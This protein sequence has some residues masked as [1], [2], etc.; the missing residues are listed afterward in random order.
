MGIGELKNGRL[1]LVMVAQHQLP[2]ADWAQWQRAIAK[3]SELLYDA[4]QGQLQIGN[5]Y[6]ADDGNGEDTADVVLYASGDPSF[7]Q[8]RFGARGAAV[9]L[10]PY[11]KR[12]VLTVLHELGHNIWNLGE[13]YSQ[14]TTSHV[15]DTSTPSPNA[16][17]IPILASGLST[18]QLVDEN[19]DALLTING[20]IE[21][22]AVVANTATS[23]TVDAD[24]SALP[25]SIGNTT[26]WIQRPAECAETATPNFCIMENSRSAAGELAPDGTWTPA[27]NPITEFCTDT[28]HDPDGDTA[29]QTRNADS[30]W[31]TIVATPGYT[32]LT[33]PNPA[34]PGPAVG[35]TPV[36]FYVLD[37]D[38]RFA[39]VLDRSYSMA[40]GNKL[41]DAQHGATYWV[42]FCAVAGDQL[43][44]VWYNHNRDVLLPLTDVGTLSPAARQQ[45]DTDINAITP[46]G[47]TDIRDALFASLSEIS[48]PPT[49]AATQVAV[50]LTDGI[51]NSPWL[52]SAQEAVP[53]LRENGLRVYALGVGD[54]TEV[55]M[56]TLD[57]IAIGT[58]GRSFAVGTN[59]PNEIEAALVEIN[60]EVRGGIIDTLPVDLPDVGIGEACGKLKGHLRP[61][62]ERPPWKVIAEL[63]DLEPTEDGWRVD[64]H[65]PCV[66]TLRIPVEKG[67][68]R[69]SF[70][71]LHPEA[72]EVWLY[73]L[74]PDGVPVDIGDPGHT[75][76]RSP[77]PHEFSLVADPSPGWWTLVLV[78][79]VAGPAIRCRIVAGVENKLLHTYAAVRASAV[80]G[81]TIPVEAGASYRLPLTGL[82]V[83]ASLTTPSG[84]QVALTLADVDGSG[85]DTGAY[86]GSFTAMEAG[87]YRG[88]ITIEGAAD[89][90]TALGLT[91]SLHLEDDSPVDL[92]SDSPPFRRTIP[93]QILVRRQGSEVEEDEREKKDAQPDADIWK[94]PVPLSSHGKETDQAYSEDPA[95]TV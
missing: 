49:R 51:H 75:H 21:R 88:V 48:T 23:I 79:P 95:A 37:P 18:D 84:A 59:Q 40:D 13:E 65:D 31:E 5:V 28:N 29:Q 55:D 87:L 62:G 89:A 46:D 24:F 54:A 11:V 92:T 66:W 53:K 68:D 80:L 10:M 3:S 77:A 71:L 56:P 35:S 90:Q 2:P 47:A 52:S 86:R 61:G 58:G 12:Q 1:N 74:D 41:P 30:C 70:T 78:R 91:R 64:A 63:L 26:V 27:A 8:G 33:L 32:G 94:R 39:V 60:A 15:I 50:L 17:T 93:V 67:A 22:H 4:S 36:S 85:E 44:V 72:S 83:T 6:V 20:Q 16:H 14:A 19:A 57:D 38:P 7:S 69:C 45:L 25:T 43:C 9:H 82:H 73:L 81:D 76:V 34:A 42:E